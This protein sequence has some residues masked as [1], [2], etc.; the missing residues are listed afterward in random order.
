MRASKNRVTQEV[1]HLECTRS[2]HAWQDQGK[3]VSAYPPGT[4]HPR[5]AWW[6]SFAI[7]VKNCDRLPSSI[8]EKT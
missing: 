2:R 8:P 6:N 5:L 1:G 3:S 7:A 4:S